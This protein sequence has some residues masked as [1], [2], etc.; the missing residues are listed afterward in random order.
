MFNNNLHSS[1][2]V[3]AAVRRVGWGDRWL[4]I[5]DRGESTFQRY[6]ITDYIEGEAEWVSGTYTTSLPGAFRILATKLPDVVSDA[7]LVEK[8]DQEERLS[9]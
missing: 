7:I 5:L 2:I 1:Y 4:L 9:H 6:V 3:L 8:T